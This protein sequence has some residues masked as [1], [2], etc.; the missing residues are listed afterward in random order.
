MLPI[1]LQSMYVRGKKE[2]KAA[3]ESA[4]TYDERVGQELRGQ[5]PYTSNEQREVSFEEEVMRQQAKRE[6]SAQ[7]QQQHGLIGFR[8]HKGGQQKSFLADLGKEVARSATFQKPKHVVTAPFA[9]EGN[10]P[11]DPYAH[12]GGRSKDLFLENYKGQIP[13]YTGRR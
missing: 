9:T 2:I 7:Q 12:D 5:N 3:Y 10:L 4:G 13:G 6:M 11:T 1:S 8:Q